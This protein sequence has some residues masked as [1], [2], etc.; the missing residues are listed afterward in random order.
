[1]LRDNLIMLRNM[2]GFS[3]QELAEKIGISRQAYAKWES[4]ATIPDIE[5]CAALAAVYG[6][7]MD[8]LIREQN[9]PGVGAVPPGPKGKNI[10]GTVTINDRGQLVIPKA[11]RDELGLKG[12]QRLVLLSDEHEGLALIPA[13]WFEE[14]IHQMM[15]YASMKPDDG[16][17]SST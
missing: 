2:H 6:V 9:V 11:A 5:K 15:M 16:S 17:E 8:S 1:M 10:W 13:E 4:G 7:T 14:K 3:Q 12:G